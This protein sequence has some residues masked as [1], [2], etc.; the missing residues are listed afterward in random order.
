[1]YAFCPA[2]DFPRRLTQ[3]V[4]RLVPCDHVSYNEVDLRQG[5]MRAVA[6]PHDPAFDHL[7]PAFGQFMHQHPVIRH[8][9]QTGQRSPLAISDFLPPSSFRRLG[10]YCE[11]FRPLGLEDQLSTTFV[12]LPGV[13]LV[14]L[15]LNRGALFTERERAVLE[16]LRPHMARAYLNSVRITQAMTSN[17]DPESAHRLA[18]LT[19]RQYDLLRLIA[20]GYTNAQAAEALDIRVGTVKKHVEHVLERLGVET[21][22]AAASL[23]LRSERICLPTPWWT[24]EVAQ[25][26]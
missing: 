18:Q 3:I 17:G 7:G 13:R 21:R 2:E 1:L 6:E 8:V 14:A 16:M 23:Y 15:A 22:L 10:L 24:I 9:A 20:G 26:R 19:D 4:T 11:F 5:T 12:A 25:S